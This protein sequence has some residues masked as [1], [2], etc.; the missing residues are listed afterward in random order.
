MDYFKEFDDYVSNYN[1]DDI[2]IKLKYN[3]SYRVMEL[4]K[5]YSKLLGFTKE[6]QELASLIGLLHD[7]GRFKQLEVYHTYN[8][9]KSIDHAE[10]GADILFKDGLINKFWSNEDDYKLIEYAIRNHNKYILK[11][12]NDERIMKFSKFI[13]DVDKVDILFVE[14]KLDELHLRTDKT[15]LSKEVVEAIKNHKG[16]DLKY[17]KSRNDH[18]A[19]YFSYPFDINND[20]VLEELKRNLIWYYETVDEANKLKE[21]YIESIK[22][23]D[24]RIDKNVRN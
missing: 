24:E 1:F 15:D 22:Y 14:G 2:N 16:V 7:I 21:V 8:D 23:I 12:I 20:I 4:S 6:E 3:H 17:V 10:Y 18:L 9:K 11:D 19:L 13:R 5:K